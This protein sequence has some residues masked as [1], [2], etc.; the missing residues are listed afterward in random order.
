MENNFISCRWHFV[1]NNHTSVRAEI[2]DGFW[3]L[4]VTPKRCFGNV[5]ICTYDDGQHPSQTMD[6]FSKSPTVFGLS[7][8]FCSN[9]VKVDLLVENRPCHRVSLGV[10]FV[11]ECIQVGQ[12]RIADIQVVLWGFHQNW[13]SSKGG[14]ILGLKI[15]HIL[16]L[17]LLH[18]AFRVRLRGAAKNQGGRSD[19]S[20]RLLPIVGTT[21]GDQIWCQM[22]ISENEM[23]P[24]AFSGAYN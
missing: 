1:T 15:N 11:K 12:Q 4:P 9:S 13:I 19:S 14:W 2:T 18:R 10:S 22:T 17:L 7:E 20:K 3:W 23:M 16:L 8:L 21:N 6:G 24:N 5:D